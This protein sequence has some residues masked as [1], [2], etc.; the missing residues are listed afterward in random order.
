MYKVL[1]FQQ[2]SL[3]WG[4]STNCSWPQEQITEPKFQALH[5]TMWRFFSSTCIVAAIKFFFFFD[6]D[7]KNANFYYYITVHICSQM[8]CFVLQWVKLYIYIF[9]GLYGP[10]SGSDIKWIIAIASFYKRST[11]M[12]GG[13][14]FLKN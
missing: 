5:Q 14:S 6:K 8:F 13:M 7:G 12:L 1:P 10:I 4:F 11:M 2:T 3:I 9:F